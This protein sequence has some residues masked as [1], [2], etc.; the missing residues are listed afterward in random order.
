MINISDLRDMLVFE[1]KIPNYRFF[2]DD[3]LIIEVF[4]VVMVIQNDEYT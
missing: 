4:I 1:W 3:W 2:G